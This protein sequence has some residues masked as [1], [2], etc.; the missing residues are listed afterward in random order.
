MTDHFDGLVQALQWKVASLSKFYESEIYSVT[1][2]SIVM[3]NLWHNLQLVDGSQVLDKSRSR[4]SLPLVEQELLTF[5]EHL[6]SSPVFSGVRVTRSL[7][8]CVCFVD[9]CLSFCTSSFGHCSS[10]IDGFWLPLWYFQTLLVS[11]SLYTY[12]IGL[13]H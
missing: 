3:C 5:P 6:S 11:F 4:R 7:I 8:L 2:L 12:T 9:R 1:S 13:H 10:S